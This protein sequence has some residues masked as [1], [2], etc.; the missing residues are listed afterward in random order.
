[1]TRQPGDATMK[2]GLIDATSQR[3][4]RRPPVVPAEIHPRSPSHQAGARRLMTFAM[5]RLETS[6]P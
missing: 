2:G 3:R 5:E 4:I 1:M 6:P